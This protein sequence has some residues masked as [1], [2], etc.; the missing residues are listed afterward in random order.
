MRVLFPGIEDHP[1][2]RELEVTRGPPALREALQHLCGSTPIVIGCPGVS[3]LSPGFVLS[4]SLEFD[5]LLHRLWDSFWFLLPAVGLFLFYGGLYH[6]K[7]AAEQGRAVVVC[8]KVL[9]SHLVGQ[10]MD[11]GPVHRARSILCPELLLLF[12]RVS[13]GG[14]GEC[15]A[16]PASEQALPSPCFSHQ[17]V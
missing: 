16:I 2:L 7:A 17:D 12:P 1:V 9:L 10:G 6:S 3:G 8:F 4:P 14:Q 15:P 13:T 5:L 11:E